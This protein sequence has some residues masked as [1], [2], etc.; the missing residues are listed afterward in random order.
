MAGEGLLAVSTG[1]Q[2]N[3]GNAE[4]NFH[5]KTSGEAELLK[6]KVLRDGRE[7]AMG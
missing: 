6:I 2:E 1:G 5:T 3:V 7:R 4:L